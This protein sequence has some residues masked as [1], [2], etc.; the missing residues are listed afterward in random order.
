MMAFNYLVMITAGNAIG[1]VG[2]IKSNV[3]SKK[4]KRKKKSQLKLQLK[5]QEKNFRIQSD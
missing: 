2:A 4:K 3:I 1:K 5:S